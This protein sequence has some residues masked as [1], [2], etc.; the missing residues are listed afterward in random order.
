MEAI[1]RFLKEE[2]GLTT[3]EYAIAGGLVGAVVI[4]NFQS[5][6]EAVGNV[7]GYID[8]ELRTNANG[9]GAGP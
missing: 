7:I 3:V 2:E 4:L 1:K 8:G 5:L 9:A 6:G